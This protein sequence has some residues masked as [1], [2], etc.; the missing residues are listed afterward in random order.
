[1]REDAREV[2]AVK[3]EYAAAIEQQSAWWRFHKRHGEHLWNYVM[4]DHEGRHGRP[5][6]IVNGKVTDEPYEITAGGKTSL[7]VAGYFTETILGAGDTY[8][9]AANIQRLILGAA[10]TLPDATFD[11]TML[12]SQVGF[13]RFAEPLEMGRVKPPEHL[14]NVPKEV[15]IFASAMGWAI[16][17]RI[18]EAFRKPEYDGPGAEF[19]FYTESEMFGTHG[20][21]PVAYFG[22]DAGGSWKAKLDAFEQNILIPQGEAKSDSVA[23]EIAFTFALLLFMNQRILATRVEHL[24]RATRRRAER[25]ELPREHI[26]VITLRRFAERAPSTD[27]EHREVEWSCQ[28]SVR[29]HWRKQP[30]PSQTDDNGR[31]MIRPIWIEP[32]TKG[33]EGKPFKD[34]DTRRLFGVTR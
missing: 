10:K 26:K 8:Y 16:D 33:P 25:D 6:R 1:M 19:V 4:N 18:P 30:Y 22:M 20:Y 12:P 5:R 34:D 21:W 28:W 3:P 7:A 32:Y 24:D 11:L 13:L 14:Q 9:V 31:T 2:E 27:D 29:G 23:H 17:K 15:P